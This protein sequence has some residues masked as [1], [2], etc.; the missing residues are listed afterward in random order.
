[1]GPEQSS[2]S[3]AIHHSFQKD[4]RYFERKHMRFVEFPSVNQAKLKKN[5]GYEVEEFLEKKSTRAPAASHLSPADAVNVLFPSILDSTFSTRIKSM[6]CHENTSS[7]AQQS[8]FR[9]QFIWNYGA[10]NFVSLIGSFNH[11]SEPI[12]LIPQ[13]SFQDTS[14]PTQEDITN[15]K[16]SGEILAKIKKE[17]SIYQ[18]KVKSWTKFWSVI[19][20]IPEG[21]H[22]YLFIVDGQWKYDPKQPFFTDNCEN[23]YNILTLQP[24]AS[25]LFGQ[26]DYQLTDNEI[27]SHDITSFQDFSYEKR[28]DFAVNLGFNSK[29][30][31]G[32]LSGAIHSQRHSP[33]ESKEVFAQSQNYS[34]GNQAD[35]LNERETNEIADEDSKSCL[36]C[37]FL[38]EEQSSPSE[39]KTDYSG[40]GVV[41]NSSV[42]KSAISLINAINFYSS[43]FNHKMKLNTQQ[44]PTKSANCIKANTKLSPHTLF[45]QA[46][47]TISYSPPMTKSSS[48]SSSVSQCS[49]SAGKMPPSASPFKPFEESRPFSSAAST[50]LDTAYTASTTISSAPLPTFCASPSPPTSLSDS[51]DVKEPASNEQPTADEYFDVPVD[52]PVSRRPPPLLMPPPYTL[53]GCNAPSPT[54]YRLSPNIS[55]QVPS[56]GQIQLNNL[57]PYPSP[58]T[59]PSLFSACA[60]PHSLSSSLPSSLPSSLIPTP[61]SFLPLPSSFYFPSTSSTYASS[62]VRSTSCSYSLP[63]TAISPGFVPCFSLHPSPICSPTSIIPSSF[64][65]SSE[66]SLVFSLLKNP[67]PLTS[68]SLA[69]PPCVSPSSPSSSLT[70]S[71][72]LAL[73]SFSPSPDKSCTPFS[74]VSSSLSP[75]PSPLPSPFPFPFPSPSPSATVSA[76][77][78]QP[79][80]SFLPFSPIQCQSQ[81][82][83]S[84]YSL[85]TYSPTPS[86]PFPDSTA[87]A[88]AGNKLPPITENKETEKCIDKKKE[89][90]K[91]II[92]NLFNK[93]FQR[94]NKRKKEKA[95]NGKS[96]FNVIFNKRN[97]S[98][99]KS[100]DHS[101]GETTPEQK[102]ESSTLIKTNDEGNCI[103]TTEREKELDKPESERS[104]AEDDDKSNDKDLSDDTYFDE[105]ESSFESDFSSDNTEVGNEDYF[106][107]GGYYYF[108]DDFEDDKKKEEENEDD[109]EEEEEAN[110]KH[111]SKL[112]SMG[113]LFYDPNWKGRYEHYKRQRRKAGNSESESDSS[114]EADDG[115]DERKVVN[116]ECVLLQLE[117]R[118]EKSARKR[119]VFSLCSTQSSSGRKKNHASTLNPFIMKV[120][121][122]MI[123]WTCLSPPPGLYSCNK[124]E[125]YLLPGELEVDALN[126]RRV[127]GFEADLMPK[128]RRELANHLCVKCIERKRIKRRRYEEERE[129]SDRINEINERQDLCDTHKGNEKRE[130]INEGEAQ[131]EDTDS[132]QSNNRSTDEKEQRNSTDI[133]GGRNSDE[134]SDS[135][136][137]QTCSTSFQSLPQQNCESSQ[138]TTCICDTSK[139]L[140]L[141]G[142]KTQMAVSL[143]PYLPPSHSKQN[144]AENS[145]KECDVC[146]ETPSS[147]ISAASMS[148]SA[149]SP[150]SSS[151]NNKRSITEMSKA[152]RDLIN[153][154]PG[155]VILN[156]S[157]T[158]LLSMA[159]AY[160]EKIV[161]IQYYT[162]AYQ[163]NDDE[164]FNNLL[165]TKILAYIE[166]KKTVSKNKEKA[167]K[168]GEGKRKKK[169]KKKKEH[170]EH[171]ERKEHKE[172]D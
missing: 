160:K 142:S 50:H 167:E 2:T 100:N 129:E 105:D 131:N 119:N 26:R 52:C 10:C 82:S 115:I 99:N 110:K 67:Q 95:K 155:N 71:Y 43:A 144:G 44:S 12:K 65:P 90:G 151:S 172:K 166:K 45:S 42:Q 125:P 140:P 49:A 154:I 91:N 121:S 40:K 19:L 21:N 136:S 1:M 35:K 37:I 164:D 116:G 114:L 9:H 120:N 147:S 130:S 41:E 133:S 60:S 109:E 56:V 161:T 69:S 165:S 169:N 127:R 86:H 150:S 141:E 15:G 162:K 152:K 11:W 83:S 88:I 57:T 124:L 138:K 63:P 143:A 4:K 89:T 73:S 48:I 158:H 20:T 51:P 14:G 101:K 58:S 126:M 132:K 146:C 103:T 66:P 39:K 75:S 29:N 32:L 34:S 171:K 30:T 74:S 61:N 104:A 118:T 96:L 122:I 77:A 153:M 113:C 64:S 53:L 59:A 46:T 72:S 94:Q 148:I 38:E 70:S 128:V 47:S 102:E 8:S 92:E 135:P 55:P 27:H 168:D 62:S 84:S 163:S 31:S 24:F 7:C 25:T 17:K 117:E 108:W 139:Y 13:K 85:P 78:S 16:I 159:L 80:S 87:T 54:S 23:I 3:S 107:C 76:S 156:H 6:H 134:I 18:G 79:P 157:P 98:A 22:F 36:K 145:M 106:K 68:D 123:D 93:F 111:G 170:K 149:S 81:S 33:D 28:D 5:F 137:D 97:E 112:R